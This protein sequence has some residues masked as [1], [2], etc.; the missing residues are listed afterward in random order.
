[1]VKNSQ[2]LSMQQ[3]V[4]GWGLAVD[5]S[6]G[7]PR[8]LGVVYL[9]TPEAAAGVPGAIG[10]GSSRLRLSTRVLGTL[11]RHVKAGVSLG[12][13]AFLL[14]GT[15]G[16][17]AKAPGGCVAITAMHVTGRVDFDGAG[18][19]PGMCAPSRRDDPTSAR[20]GVLALGTQRGV[21]AA[22]IDLLA[23]VRPDNALPQIGSLNGWRPVLVPGDHGTMVRMYGAESGFQPGHIV[24]PCAQL[25]DLQD[26]ILAAI[27]SEEGDSGAALVDE[28]NI[29]LGFLVG[30]YTAGQ[31][32]LRVFSPAGHVL[33]RL[34]CQDIL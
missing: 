24:D 12:P 23:D 29:V 2:Q 25:P 13:E 31:G 6:N 3:G 16:C 1:M 26:A 27:Y 5:M 15:L 7:R 28:N 9:R 11:D 8:P 22:R 19:K 20:V 34:N 14:K 17:F 21:D 30:R 4:V 18:P 10:R 32:L 33:S